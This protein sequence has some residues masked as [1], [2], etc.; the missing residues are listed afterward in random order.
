MADTGESEIGLEPW[1]I[2]F[3]QRC[4]TVE[5]EPDFSVEGWM[6]SNCTWQC[7]AT[8]LAGK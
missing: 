8:L 1:M 5:E 6:I 7:T 2:N 4:L 3:E